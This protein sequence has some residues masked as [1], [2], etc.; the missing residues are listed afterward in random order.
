MPFLCSASRASADATISSPPDSSAKCAV[1]LTYQRTSSPH[2]M[3]TT[4]SLNQYRHP[5]RSHTGF[6]APLMS[7]SER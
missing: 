7:S 6:A 1:A 5:W 3:G 2:C 4:M